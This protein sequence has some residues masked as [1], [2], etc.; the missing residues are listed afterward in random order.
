MPAQRR[1]QVSDTAELPRCPPAPVTVDLAT[2]AKNK[3]EASGDTFTSI[4]NITGSSHNDVLGGDGN[5]NV[6]RG[7]GG[8]DTLWGHAGTDRL[9]GGAGADTLNGGDDRDR[10]IGGPG[11]DALDGGDDEDIASYETSTTGITVDLT[12]PTNNTGDAV[13][14]TF[15]SIERLLG[16]PYD[17]KIRADGDAH[18][19]IGGPGADVLDGGPVTTSIDTAYYLTAASGITLDLATPSNNTG[20]AKG[21]TFINIK[22]HWGS[23]H[24]DIMRGDGNANTLDGDGGND[25]I[26]GGAGNDDL[27]GWTGDDKLSDRSG[28]DTFDGGA[29][30]DKIAFGGGTDT[31]E[32]G[33]DADEFF[34]HDGGT[35]TISDYAAGGEHLY[36][37]RTDFR[38]Y[39]CRLH[40]LGTVRHQQ[41]G[42]YRQPGCQRQ[43]DDARHHHADRPGH[44]R[45][46]QR[47]GMV[48]PQRS[49]VHALAID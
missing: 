17:D 18:I 7:S 32:G 48:Q 46:F 40:Q 8:N 45:S 14:D 20:D 19:L 1:R 44:Q 27:S 30:A 37:C 25:T 28:D 34:Y 12:T 41:P 3:G 13:G 42:H 29:G 15:T 11:A 10:L 2:P 49:P 23:P 4:E 5:A 24:D 39:G 22:W 38:Q 47:S 31:V 21:D 16:S 43:P 35:H 33:A 26:D 6:L 36:L 9:F